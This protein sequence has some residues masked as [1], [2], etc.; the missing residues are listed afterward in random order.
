V[1][2]NIV[3]TIF[4]G[5]Y[6]G[7][8]AL[9]ALSVVFPLQMLAM[10]IG[11]MVGVGGASLISR[12]IGRNDRTGAERALGNSISVGLLL[13]LLLTAIVLPNIDYWAKLIGASEKVLPLAREYLLIVMSGAVFSVL[14]STL[15]MHIRAEG[16]ARVS[17]TTMI[18]A[19]GLNIIFD[20]IFIIPL[21]MG[22]GGAALATVISQLIATVYALSYYFTRKSYLGLHFG[23]FRPDFKILKLIFAIGVAQFTQM[24]ATSIAAMIIVKMAATYGG[25][26]A[27]SS[28]GIIQRLLTFAMMP[29]MV[30]SQGMQPIVGFNYGA[31]RFHHVLKT[32]TLAAISSTLLSVSLFLV[33]LLLPGPIIRIFTGDTQLIDE[34]IH[35]MHIVFLAL[36]VLGIFNVGQQVFLSTGKA[37][38]SFIVAILRPAAFMIPSVLI[39]T[40]FFGVDGVW[41]SLPA[42]D[43]LTCVLVA[44]L[45][46]PLLRKF[47]K[48]AALGNLPESE[49]TE[50]SSS[51]GL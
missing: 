6:V 44:I 8:S 33:L 46:I 24:I 22:I 17:M 15:M 14:S 48:A 45:I 31:D 18:I 39:L 25:D 7:T 40:R 43:G 29:G 9:A 41:M 23:N 16:N 3:D 21:K 32:I 30:I 26:L 47:R 4:I 19:F 11:N 1:L 37:V 28:F 10:G 12:L 36:P 13:A 50:I 2:Y 20:A 35:V 51:I 5:H 34:G 27:L 49:L 42:S 38:E